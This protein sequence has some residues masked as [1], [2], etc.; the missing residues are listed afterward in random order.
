MLRFIRR[1]IPWN[2]RYRQHVPPHHR[3][4]IGTHRLPKPNWFVGAAE[5]PSVPRD[6]ALVTEI[7]DVKRRLRDY[8]SGEKP[9]PAADAA[10]TRATASPQT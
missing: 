6:P 5:Q 2:Y 8:R 10:S 3:K 4:L 1:L 7:E 9:P